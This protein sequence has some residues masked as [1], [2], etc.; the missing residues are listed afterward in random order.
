MGRLRIAPCR[1]V[2]LSSEPLKKFSTTT[3]ETRQ[4]AMG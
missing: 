1:P 2:K 3:P 4:R